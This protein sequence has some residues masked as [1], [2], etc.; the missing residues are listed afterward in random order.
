MT[1]FEDRRR[2]FRL[3]EGGGETP[4]A[5]PAP[6]EKAER[7]HVQVLVIDARGGVS[8]TVTEA[9]AADRIWDQIG[10]SPPVFFDLE[11]HEMPVEAM[12]KNYFASV[13]DFFKT[14]AR[15]DDE[16]GGPVGMR[17]VLHELGPGVSL[18]N[19]TTTLEEVIE[20]LE[21]AGLIERVQGEGEDAWVYVGK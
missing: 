6:A 2:R 17:S 1:E 20:Q 7:E 15:D 19:F 4:A 5:A 8:A 10:M 18:P 11:E 12:S 14:C 9:R 3:V 21:K 13:L 16:Y